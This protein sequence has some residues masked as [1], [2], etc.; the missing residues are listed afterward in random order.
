MNHW[1]WG[2]SVITL[3]KL[4]L[5]SELLRDVGVHLSD[6]EAD[7]FLADVKEGIV[8]YLGT[9]LGGGSQDIW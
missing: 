2:G 6:Q 1:E 3:P 7:I 8:N 4:Y 9:R 5:V